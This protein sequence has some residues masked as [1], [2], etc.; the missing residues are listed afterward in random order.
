VIAAVVA[1][2]FQEYVV[3]PEAVSVT[4]APMQ[5][6][7][8]F[9][10]PEVS[11]T[12]IAAEGAGLTVM[13]MVAVAVQPLAFVTVAVYVVEILGVIMITAVVA[14]VFQEYVVPPEAV[15]VA[16][17]PSHIVPSFG[18][19]EVSTTAIA[20]IGNGLTVIVA[21]AVAVQPL[22]LVTVAV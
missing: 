13:V 20:A 1:P 10:V 15:S 14:P 16:E 22:A 7:P 11:V 4:E 5:I 18:V 19:P 2:V 8:S 12:A 21:V 9:G 3:P 17:D 6:V